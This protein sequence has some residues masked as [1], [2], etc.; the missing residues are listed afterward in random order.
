MKTTTIPNT[1]LKISKICLGT[2]T[3]GEQNSE[4]EAHEQLDYAVSRGIN[5]IDTAEMYPIA[6]RKE[7]LGSTERFI[8]SWLNKRGKRDDLIIATK[9]AGPNRGMEY[10]RKPLDFSAKSIKEAVDLSLKNLQTD[11][12]DLYQM[13]WPERVMNMFGKRGL[14]GIDTN[15]KENFAEVLSVYD[16][17]IKAGKIRHIGVSNEAP[18]AVMKFISESEKHNLPR[19]ATIQN[20]Y[21]LLNRLFEVGLTE[22]CMRE[23]IGLMAYSPLG[24]G[25]LSGKHLNGTQ[26]NSRIDLFPQFTRYTSEN[27]TK[28]TKLY[29]ELAQSHGLT[30]TQM[31]L[32]FVQQQQFVM[33]T[34]I[35]A[36]SLAQLKENIDSHEIVLSEEILKEI[37]A[38]QEMIP[39]P[40]P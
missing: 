11:Y 21:S 13:H 7:T 25:I 18:W 19:I 17:L 16:E 10:I 29:Q 34:I 27:A 3:F 24:F 28:A 38:I 5:F 14:T 22:V 2:M 20:P 4:S 33:S 30:L 37:D 1:S 36:T 31:A 39:N 9:I 23:N 35:G 12:I 8:G 15:W 32:A 40:A 26:S 6:S